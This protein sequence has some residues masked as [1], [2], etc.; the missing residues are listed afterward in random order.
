[1]FL[2]I[3][4]RILKKVNDVTKEGRIYIFLT[5]SGGYFCSLIFIL[6]LI[7]LSYANSLA[8]FCSFLF[9]SIVWVSCVV[10]NYNL[11]GLEVLRLKTEDIY[12]E[13]D[14]VLVE[15]DFKNKGK[16][17]RFDIEASIENSESEFVNELGSG[18]SAS[19][20][21]FLT[22]RRVGVYTIKKA[23]L[24]TT[25]PFGLFRS[26]KPYHFKK[27]IY[28]LP[29]PK[30]HSLPIEISKETD[31]GNQ[32]SNQLNDEFKSHK[33]YSREGV[34]RIDWKIFAR[35]DELLL[36]EY[37]GEV[38]HNYKFNEKL[39]GNNSFKEKLAIMTYWVLEA[40]KQGASYSLEVHGDLVASGSGKKHLYRCLRLV[41]SR[42]EIR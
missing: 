29:T 28:V 11:H 23:D 10:T 39:L 31:E 19:I 34:G 26:W 41:A 3:K 5:I 36:K 14:P 40:E 17:P 27:E 30:H 33:K 22:K 35:R 2:L 42:G 7:S 20:K 12:F 8:Y 37:E 24:C 1:M 18:E 9:L 13:N 6:F 25:F 16:K 4:K 38:S 32:K 21:I 15:L